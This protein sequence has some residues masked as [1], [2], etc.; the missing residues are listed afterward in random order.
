MKQAGDSSS[1]VHST[2]VPRAVRD[3]VSPDG[4]S[5]A[6]TFVYDTQC[7]VMLINARR[8]HVDFTNPFGMDFLNPVRSSFVDR[9]K[10]DIHRVDQKGTA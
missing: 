1:S 5:L 3:A 4:P 6:S 7:K 2:P 8:R 10:T 9:N